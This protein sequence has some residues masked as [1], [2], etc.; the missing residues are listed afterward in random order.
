MNEKDNPFI[1]RRAERLK[2][3]GRPD[4]ADK[5]FEQ[6]PPKPVE[7]AAT[8][9]FFNQAALILETLTALRASGYTP[10]PETERQ[11]Y[12]AMDQAGDDQIRSLII[13]ATKMDITRQPA[14]YDAVINIALN[15]GIIPRSGKK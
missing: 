4:L 15:R 1:K 11:H 3:E 2:K 13:N 12:D 8:I 14:Y 6:E 10:T 7:K 9:L 5:L